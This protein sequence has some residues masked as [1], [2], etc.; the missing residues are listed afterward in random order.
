MKEAAAGCPGL[1]DGRKTQNMKDEWGR[2]GQGAIEKSQTGKERK[3]A[4]C[5]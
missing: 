2:R 5:H 3:T 1:K 4:H